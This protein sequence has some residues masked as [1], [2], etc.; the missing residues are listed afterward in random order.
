MPKQRLHP[1]ILVNYFF[2]FADQLDGHFC[3]G[4]ERSLY[5]GN[6]GASIIKFAR[7]NRD[8]H[9]LGPVLALYV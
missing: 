6:S 5:Q 2:G 4:R 3:R 8:S 7:C 1:L 9:Q